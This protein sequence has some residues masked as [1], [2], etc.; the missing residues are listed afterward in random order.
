VVAAAQ[1]PARATVTI[2]L[3]AVAANVELL[4]GRTGGAE[5][6]AVVKADG[7][8][9]GAS[10]VGAAA[11]AAGA[12]RLCVATWEEARAVRAELP[13]APVLVMGPLTPGEEAEVEGVDVAIPSM[14]AFARLRAAARSPLAVHVKADTGMG[15]WGVGEGDALRLAELLDG[16]GPLRLGGLMSHL[17]SADDDREHTDR[18]LE[19]F[20]A[21]GERF[22]ACPRHIANSAATLAVDGAAFDAVRCGI[23]V[24]GLSPFNDDPAGHGLRPAMRLESYVAQLKLLQPGES[25]GYGRRFIAERPTWIG[26]APAGYAD[27]VPR[28]LSGR[29]DVL[30][31]GRR[32]RVAATISMDQLTFVVGE[33]CDVELG[34]TVTLIGADGDERIGAEEWAARSDTIAYEIVCDIAPRR[35][36]VEHVV[37]GR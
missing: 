25:A 16:S 27:G 13:Q 11:L 19:R 36:R 17:S 30:V 9:H 26:L 29:M 14:E 34:D 1:R 21:L 12:T 24:Y 10:S 7:Y 15:R 20:A 8:G 18:Q 28:L 5:L 6:W 22:P 33:R 35:R 31:R 23:A 4:R 3:A 37:V 2:D 32:R